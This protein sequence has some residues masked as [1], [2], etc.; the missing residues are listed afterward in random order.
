MNQIYNYRKSH[1]VTRTNDEFFLDGKYS[2]KSIKYPVDSEKYNKY[3]DKQE[4]YSSK[5][6]I[7]DGTMLYRVGEKNLDDILNMLV[8]CSWHT[9]KKPPAG[10]DAS[11]FNDREF[12][13]G[14]VCPTEC[15]IG[16]FLKKYD[17]YLYGRYM[18]CEDWP[19]TCQLKR[20]N[21]DVQFV[22]DI[23]PVNNVCT[24]CNEMEDECC[25]QMDKLKYCNMNKLDANE[26]VLSP[27][28]Y[29]EY[30]YAFKVLKNTDN[31]LV[32]FCVYC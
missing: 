10:L 25:G 3:L 12:P 4:Y 8:K 31:S 16:T 30:V 23:S 22:E 26:I 7:G 11:T 18:F 14:T 27:P 2:I 15:R 9:G 24:V 1:F 19:Y 32:A 5:Q 21:S 28:K 20:V 29:H 6:V 17:L 13:M